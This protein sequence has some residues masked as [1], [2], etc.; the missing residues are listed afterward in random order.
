MI[1]KPEVKRRTK[2]PLGDLSSLYNEETTTT[3][4]DFPEMGILR[5]N[6]AG[7]TKPSNRDNVSRQEIHAAITN[8]AIKK[9][10]N[11]LKYPFGQDGNHS[12][13]LVRDPA[14]KY[15]RY[16]I[17][18]ILKINSNSLLP[19]SWDGK[20]LGFIPAKISRSLSNDIN[21]FTGGAIFSVEEQLHNKYFLVK[22][23]LS[24]GSTAFSKLDFVAR[25]RFSAI[26]GE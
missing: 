10:L 22:V 12:I 17:H 2:S 9:N 3:I 1:T 11:E 14:N 8:L 23:A 4:I 21:Y 18:L 26:L 24:Y 25:N 19:S 5:L 7:Y 16:A 13:K 6:P 15:D 20:D